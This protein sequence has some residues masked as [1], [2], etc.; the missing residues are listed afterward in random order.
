MTA[1]PFEIVFSDEAL[2]VLQDL[3]HKQFS[4]KQ[5]KVQKALRQLRDFGPSYPALRTHLMQSIRGNN[6]EPV[7][8]SYVEND[9]PSAWRIWW[10]YSE[11]ADQIQIVMIGPHP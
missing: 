6:G 7:Y 2:A 1:P 10:Q 11:S 9:T 4:A 3:G 8:Q 5:K